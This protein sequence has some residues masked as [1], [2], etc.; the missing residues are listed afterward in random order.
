MTNAGIGTIPIPDIQ[1]GDR[2]RR[3]AGDLTDL[4]KSI[5]EISLLQPIGLG[6]GNQ[7]LYGFRRLQA[8]KQLGWTDISYV[9]PLDRDDALAYLM[10]ER[11]E[12]TCRKPMTPSELVALGR[13]IEELERPKARENLREGGRRGGQSL[14]SA[15]PRLEP[16]ST[17][18][19]VGEV[20]GISQSTYKR[21][22]QVDRAKQ[23]DDPDIAQL[24]QRIQHEL[25]EEL[26]SP[27]AAAETIREA[28]RDSA[29][30]LPTKP[31]SGHQP[32]HL[33]ILTNVVNTLSGIAVVL[34]DIK[35][36][37]DTVTASEA[38][39]IISELDEHIQP[40]KRVRTLLKGCIQ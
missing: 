17:D 2:A 38:Q 15:E 6:P 12:N 26:I 23:D 11:D 25:D 1:I 34:N 24:A 14:G 5:S 7:L 31:L 3:D 28:K 9:R 27:R 19:K 20:L 32:N 4:K 30:P 37:N 29:T 18:K 21:L 39:R 13:R 36:V 10:A 33:K 35:Q 16:I 22:K 40:I 8:C